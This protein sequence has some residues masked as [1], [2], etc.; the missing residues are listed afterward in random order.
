MM[1][2]SVLAMPRCDTAGISIP[3]VRI[4][5]AN[6]RTFQGNRNYK[7]IDMDRWLEDFGNWVWEA[8]AGGFISIGQ[9]G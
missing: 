1:S 8:F 4:G 9:E 5:A 7:E 3:A 6:A 2:G